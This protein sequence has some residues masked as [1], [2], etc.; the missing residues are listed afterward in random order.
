MSKPK[1][2]II[3]DP[4]LGHSGKGRDEEHIS[5]S[6]VGWGEGR[7]WLWRGNPGGFWGFSA[8][9]H[10]NYGSG[11]VMGYNALRLM[12]LKTKI[13]NFTVRKLKDNFQCIKNNLNLKECLRK[14]C[15]RM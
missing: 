3:Y 8:T 2:D 6:E 11:Y 1:T 4:I 15:D 14:P 9:L 7:K 10:L 13:R 5:N 12:E